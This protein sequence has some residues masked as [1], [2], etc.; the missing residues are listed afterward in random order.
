VWPEEEVKRAKEI[1]KEYFELKEE[2]GSENGK[3][4]G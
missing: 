2:K 1:R 3:D 4:F